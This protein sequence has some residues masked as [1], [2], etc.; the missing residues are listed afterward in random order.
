MLRAAAP[1]YSRAGNP[2]GPDWTFSGG[3]GAGEQV[4][5][6][7][8]GRPER[9]INSQ[10]DSPK[11]E[12]SATWQE[13][14]NS[15]V[16][17]GT[18]FSCEISKYTALPIRIT[19]AGEDLLGQ[20][21]KMSVWRAPTDNDRKIKAKWGHPNTWEGEN[22]DRIFNHV[23]SVEQTESGL[24]FKGSLA[25]VGRMPFMQ[26]ALEYV[27]TSHG[28]LQFHIHADVRERCMWLPRFGFEFALVLEGGKFQY[29]GRGSMENYSDMHTHTTTGWFTSSAEEEYFPYIMPQEHGNHTGCKVLQLANGLHFTSDHAFEM[30]VSEYSTEALTQAMHIDELRKNGF[31][32]VR[33]DYKNS[34]LGSNSCGPEL[35]KKSIALLRKSLISYLQR[36]WMK[37]KDDF[38]T[39]SNRGGSHLQ[40]GK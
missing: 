8:R 14:E 12:I 20:P 36:E 22:Y 11:T 30:Q 33:I 17:F 35:L 6:Q 10:T 31:A 2:P 13:L 28:E 9:H 3:G 32:N 39:Y 34:G 25:G 16:F 37:L 24:Y 26:Y 21:V 29:F 38:R 27:P 15:Y 40:D 23:Y 1:F 7:G 18:G 19:R 4:E 5:R